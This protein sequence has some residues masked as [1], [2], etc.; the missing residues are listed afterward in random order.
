MRTAT[1]AR[2]R[3]H[4][5]KRTGLKSKT[6]HLKP[7]RRPRSRS[8]SS[9][10]FF[11]GTEASGEGE[12]KQAPQRHQHT[13]TMR[14]DLLF[15]MLHAANAFTGFSHTAL[16]HR[17]PPARTTHFQANAAPS[18][19][20][21]VEQKF[22][23]KQGTNARAAALM[24]EFYFPL[25]LAQ[26][27]VASAQSFPTRFWIV[28]DSGSMASADGKMITQSASG[29]KSI[30]GATRW[31]EISADMAVAA[32]VSHEVGACTEFHPLN[33]GRPLTI[34]GTDKGTPAHIFTSARTHTAHNTHART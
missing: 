8:L 29:A 9:G 7:E 17:A 28:D 5:G 4:P 3:K 14:A 31:Q 13:H 33:G 18:D 11:A 32:A 27:V 10:D 34:Q 15:V 19:S 2:V 6:P 16:H 24:E 21:D 25:G 22:K 20:A 26:Q 12:T 1:H 23:A 30:V